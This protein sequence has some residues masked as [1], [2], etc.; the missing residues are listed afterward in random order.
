MISINNLEFSYGNKEVL[1]GVSMRIETGKVYGLLGLNGSGKTTLFN[2]IYGWL[3]LQAGTIVFD[4]GH[5]P[6]KVTAFVESELFF[7]SHITAREHLS[8]FNHA[9]RDIDQL[10]NLLQL[11]LDNLTEDFSHGMKKKLALL[12][13]FVSGKLFFILDEPFNGLDLESIEVVKQIIAKLNSQGI[14][15]IISSHMIETLITGCD[16]ICY[17]NDGRI[18]ESFERDQFHRVR[19]TILADIHALTSDKIS[20]AMKPKA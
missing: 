15:F 20:E 16:C 17:L 11:P 7:Y 9:K 4:G 2:C 6:K 8:L 10:A 19:E 14:T 12:S 1:K 3:K 5:P 13:A 18:Q